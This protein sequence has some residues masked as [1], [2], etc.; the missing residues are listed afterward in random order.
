MNW[1]IKTLG[2]YTQ[3]EVQAACIKAANNERDL[4]A[5]SKRHYEMHAALLA[6]ADEDIRAQAEARVRVA[7]ATALENPRPDISRYQGVYSTVRAQQMPKDRIFRLFTSHLGAPLPGF[8]GV[9]STLAETN[10]NG[11]DLPLVNI[12][13]I[14]VHLHT[15]NL[16]LRP[17]VA[18]WLRRYAVLRLERGSQ[19]VLTIR[20]LSDFDLDGSPRLW[21]PPEDRRAGWCI[22]LCFPD[23]AQEGRWRGAPSLHTGFD[24]RVSVYGE[25]ADEA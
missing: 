8:G 2:G 12:R 11:Y 14:G 13:A 10:L 22:Q 4:L 25:V 21:A 23:N 5:E 1:L 24:L 6:G 9:A 20:P 17:A 19:E 15:F 18:S 7:L 3:A 16:G